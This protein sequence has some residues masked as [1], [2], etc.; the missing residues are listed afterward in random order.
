METVGVQSRGPLFY[1]PIMFTDA[2]PWSLC[3]P[4]L[5]VAWWRERG[6]A[7]IHHRVRTLLLLWIAIIVIIFSFSQTKQDLYIFPI[8]TAI[9]ALGGDW[10][11][12]MLD[13]GPAAP[14]HT[15]RGWLTATLVVL[16]VVLVAI[17]SLTL[18]LF[19]EDQTVYR[20]AGAQT[21]GWL[22][23]G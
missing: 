21:T 10:V 19:G 16:A 17:G 23:L 2:L 6:R 4:A 12:R 7:D 3:L 11:A 9:A 18:Y 15:G 22:A 14:A 8:V 5:M 20:V 13:F 1:L